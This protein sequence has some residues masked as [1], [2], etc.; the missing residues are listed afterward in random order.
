M[1]GQ[2]KTVHKYVGIATVVVFLLT[3]LYMRLRFPDLYRENE[4]IRYTFRSNH[5][6]ILFAGLINITLGTY[7][8]AQYQ[9][10]KRYLQLIGSSSVLVATT[11]LI[12]AFFYEAP[13]GAPE[14]YVTSIGVLLSLIGV[15]SHM[16]G[17][18]S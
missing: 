11:L 5:V 10:R 2:M 15:I 14:R 13:V 3:G 4:I 1:R 8:K 12:F 7:L 17:G 16:S 9:K 18:H 6:Y